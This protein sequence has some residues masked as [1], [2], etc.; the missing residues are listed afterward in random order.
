MDA[1]H[2]WTLDDFL[3]VEQEARGA[4]PRGPQGAQRAARGA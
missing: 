4:A 2:R 1:E 3:W